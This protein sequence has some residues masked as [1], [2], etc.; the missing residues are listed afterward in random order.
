MM[1]SLE[2]K[3]LPGSL[4]TTVT[5]IYAMISP[6]KGRVLWRIRTRFDIGKIVETAKKVWI[7]MA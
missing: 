3:L 7:S 2:Y 1:D 4:M 5:S 6:P